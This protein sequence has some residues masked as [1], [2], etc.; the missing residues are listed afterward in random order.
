M[1]IRIRPANENDVTEIFG[2]E[3]ECFDDAWSIDS[4]YSDVVK[5]KITIYFVA[6]DEK[7]KVIGFAGMY[8]IL[9]ESHI[10]NVAVLKD[11]R[12]LGI[13]AMLISE[14]IS[15]AQ[16]SDSMGITLEVRISNEAAK[17]IYLKFGFIIEGIRKNYYQNN[18]EDAYIMWRYFT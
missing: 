9:D 1:K 16:K 8:T 14:L 5:S 11:F 12:N 17:N 2:I 18:N 13:G 7:G 15:Q 3:Q 6:Q 10:T 4:I